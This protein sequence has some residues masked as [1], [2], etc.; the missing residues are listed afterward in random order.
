MVRTVEKTLGRT[1]AINY[2]PLQQGDVSKTISDISK[3]KELLGY[4]PKVTF[5]EGIKK[6]IEWERR[7][8]Q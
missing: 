4:D 7:G 1:A 2:L 6:F 3:A 5:E 8:N